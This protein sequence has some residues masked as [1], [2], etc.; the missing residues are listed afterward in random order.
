MRGF[1]KIRGGTMFSRRISFLLSITTVLVIAAVMIRAQSVSENNHGS[2]QRLNGTFLVDVTPDLGGPPP[3]KVIRHF[4][5]VGGVLGPSQVLFGSTVCGEWLRIGH[6]E[7]AITLVSFGYAPTG[8]ISTLTK[9]RG[10][11]TLNE[12]GDELTGRF[13]TEV[14]D[15]QGNLVNSLKL[16]VHGKRVG[17]EPLPEG[18]D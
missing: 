2:H 1:P 5:P 17:V 13:K 6:S 12:D 14:F 18:L 4:T 11:V 15:L 16:S 10:R 9:S 7:F 3:F 8:L